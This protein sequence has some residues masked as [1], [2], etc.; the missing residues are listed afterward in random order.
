[1][2]EGDG[3]GIATQKVNNLLSLIDFLYFSSQ[4]YELID[5]II[6]VTLCQLVKDH[7]FLKLHILHRKFSIWIR[8]GIRDLMFIFSGMLFF[9]SRVGVV[10]D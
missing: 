3:G 1:M 6:D 8:E 5:N 9:E 7:V 2:I 4:K 10:G